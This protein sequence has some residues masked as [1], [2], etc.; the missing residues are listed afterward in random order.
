MLRCHRKAYHH[1]A[2]SKIVVIFS[3]HFCNILTPSKHKYAFFRSQTTLRCLCPQAS[4]QKMRTIC[5]NA[6][7][8]Y[9]HVLENPYLWAEFVWPFDNAIKPRFYQFQGMWIIAILCNNF[10]IFN[11]TYFFSG[12]W[13]CNLWFPFSMHGAYEQ[14]LDEDW[15]KNSMKLIK[16]VNLWLFDQRLIRNTSANMKNQRK[17]WLMKWLITPRS[18]ER[19]RERE[20]TAWSS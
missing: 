20:R 10:Q 12:H 1:T 13:R 6:D 18:I 2:R 17:Q 3:N 7:S 8:L 4:K 15:W 19:E 9:L 5:E 11:G 16:D 14:Y